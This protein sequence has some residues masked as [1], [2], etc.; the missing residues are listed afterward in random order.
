MSK[1]SKSRA[2][3]GVNSAGIFVQTSTWCQTKRLRE[4]PLGQQRS[5]IQDY[6]SPY[7]LYIFMLNTT[8]LTGFLLASSP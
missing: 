8:I 6:F 4:R 3:Q 7:S 5:A 2:P 1:M